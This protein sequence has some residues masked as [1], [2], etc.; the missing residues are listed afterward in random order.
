MEDKITL[1]GNGSFYIR[2]GWLTKGLVEIKK[3]P[4][5]FSKKYFE[6]ADALGVGSV[7]A[8]S[9]KYWLMAAG[10]IVKKAEQSP[11]K[12]DIKK[13]SF[14]SKCGKIILE[15]DKYIENKDTLWII[16]YNIAS[17]YKDAT[18][19][20]LFFN[21]VS[22]ERFNRREFEFMMEEELEK[23]GHGQESYSERSLSNDCAVLLQMYLDDNRERNPEEKMHCPLAELHLLTKTNDKYS[24]NEIKEQDISSLA[25]LYGICGYLEM[26][27]VIEKKGR[28]SV[29]I[30]NLLEDENSPGK[31]FGIN[32]IT[33]ND[34]LDALEQDGYLKIDRTAGLDTVYFEESSIKTREKVMERIYK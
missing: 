34:C 3:N 31:I 27:G 28:T 14:V 12:Y 24:R 7:M 23:R 22:E 9:I 30:E 11:V 25:V 19:W 32:R 20:N 4:E 33:L 8:K 18:I 10:L 16:H 29:S 17:N 2:E 13:G 1:K 15:N 21:S 5:L 6:G 26:A